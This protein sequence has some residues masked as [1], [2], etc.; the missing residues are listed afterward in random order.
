MPLNPLVIHIGGINEVSAMA[1]IG[2]HDKVAFSLCGVAAKDV[3]AEA[4]FMNDKVGF[5]DSDH[6][7]SLHFSNNYFDQ[8]GG[9]TVP[10]KIRDLSPFEHSTDFGVGT[11]LVGVGFT[12]GVGDL[13]GL[14]IGTDFLL[15]D[16]VPSSF[17]E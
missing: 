1:F 7:V 12:V 5:W 10:A 2:I 4:E 13:L 9:H 17:E 3:A 11:D 15:E 8:P 16:A 14:D 6:G